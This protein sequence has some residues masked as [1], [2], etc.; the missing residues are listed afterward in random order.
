MVLVT[1]N[2]WQV[3]VS[4]G[5]ECYN[6]HIAPSDFLR[7]CASFLPEVPMTVLRPRPFFL[8]LLF[9]LTAMLIACNGSSTT[10]TSTTVSGTT[11]TTTTTS[12]GSVTT[13][14]TTW[15]STTSTLSTPLTWDII[16]DPEGG[17]LEAGLADDFLDLP[18]GSTVDLPVP[19]RD[20]YEFYGWYEG[21]DSW[22]DGPFGEDFSI[23]QD[24]DLH[25]RWEVATLSPLSFHSTWSAGKNHVFH[26]VYLHDDLNGTIRAEELRI[27][28]RTEGNTDL[29]QITFNLGYRDPGNF[30]RF[31]VIDG[32]K[33]FD[34]AVIGDIRYL[35]QKNADDE[36]GTFLSL[37]SGEQPGPL[38][39]R[40]EL[41]PFDYLQPERFERIP[42]TTEFLYVPIANELTDFA[43]G[44][45]EGDFLLDEVQA[46][47]SGEGPLLII[48]IPIGPFHP[49]EQE[50]E[51][52]VTLY[53]S[54]ENMDA[55]LDFPLQEAKAFVL[56]QWT[57]LVENRLSSTLP[58]PQSEQTLT[59][60]LQSAIAALDD[61]TSVDQLYEELGLSLN[62]L[63]D[64]PL[65][66]DALHDLRSANL[67]QMEK[68]YAEWTAIATDESIDE[69]NL[70]YEAMV[71]AVLWAQ[72]YPEIT[73]ALETGWKAI[74]LDFQEDP[75][76]AEFQLF[77]KRGLMWVEEF[78]A[79]VETVISTEDP[80]RA[81][82]DTAIA[83]AK[84]ELEAWEF[85]SAQLNLSYTLRDNLWSLFVQYGGS[86]LE[87]YRT[88]ALA[89]VDRLFFETGIRGP[90]AVKTAMY[91]IISLRNNART[92]IQ[93]ATT[94]RGIWD[95][96]VGYAG[97]EEDE[98]L[99]LLRESL[100]TEQS[101]LFNH[102]YYRI[103]ADSRPAFTDE[104]L[105]IRDLLEDAVSAKTIDNLDYCFT[106]YVNELPRDPLENAKRDAIA[107]IQE[108]LIFY[109]P[110][111]TDAS[112]TD[113]Y[114]A[115]VAAY[116]Q[117]YAALT[118]EAAINAGQTG[119]M[120]ILSAFVMDWDKADLVNAR[121]GASVRMNDEMRF[122][123][124]F[125]E[126][127]PAYAEVIVL[128][129]A[130]RDNL[131]GC[132]SVQAVVDAEAAWRTAVAATGYQLNSAKVNEY[133]QTILTQLAQTLTG[134]ETVPPALQTAY[135]EAVAV[136][137]T[138][139]DPLV[140]RT[141]L[142]D[143]MQVYYASL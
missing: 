44:M 77:R 42:G 130:A 12:S 53:Y 51:E 104:Y 79:M 125:T 4:K 107:S 119:E 127:Y 106:L 18:D 41:S 65:V 11:T 72:S 128:T 59:E 13:T 29:R 62:I 10:T 34:E 52:V 141:E 2:F 81:Q 138:T 23:D 120:A 84:A 55:E 92:Q 87:I 58:T 97:N 46:L 86:G 89:E 90:D 111:A 8:S 75:L 54:W 96:L 114:N 14:S 27:S 117:I 135:D 131:L 99:D 140:I 35:F 39:S 91:P 105:R 50:W 70:S 112:Q 95:A 98:I 67:T 76:K 3:L 38:G 56:N 17:T 74:H 101:N 26:S 80:L 136:I 25:A 139:P 63:Q 126:D 115:Q 85:A 93:S 132:Y 137:S 94:Y 100:Y 9:L 123:A 113:M 7:L 37:D 82:L 45:V 109:H 116:D 88:W 133:R 108:L 69:M 6:E 40:L 121:E 118:P 71:Q 129:V 64:I 122:Y 102:T 49:E 68:D 60:A 78:Q 110:R 43:A 143:Y 124:W 142:I 31:E 32:F 73:T 36:V 47:Y 16:F 57:L 134:F 22:T 20:G 15:P 66:F 30:D 24:W 48:Q 33:R 21:P 19:V 61:I 83:S 103:P 5:G 1:P 28:C